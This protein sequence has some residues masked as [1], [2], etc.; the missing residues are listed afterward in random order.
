MPKI[1]VCKYVIFRYFILGISLPNIREK[2]LKFNFNDRCPI[3]GRKNCVVRFGTYK[4]KDGTVIQRYLCKYRLKKKKRYT[5]FSRLPWPLIPYHSHG[6]EILTTIQTALNKKLTHQEIAN[7]TLPQKHKIELGILSGS[8]TYYSRLF[9]TVILKWFLFIERN[10][11][12]PKLLT[13]PDL[14]LFV[15][16]S[17]MAEIF[18][19]NTDKFLVGTPSQ[20]RKPRAP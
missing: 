15:I 18:W 3:C 4:R 12:L 13:H 11:T 2:I 9:I 14:S 17:A 1:N 16:I 20:D 6:A 7:S 19:T 5:T 10:A 8:I